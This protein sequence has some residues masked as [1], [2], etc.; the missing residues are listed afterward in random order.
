MEAWLVSNPEIEC[1]FAANDDMA[2]GAINAMEMA[3]RMDIKV[4]SVDANELGCIALK[5]GK[6]T[7][8]VAQDTFGYAHGR[9]GLCREAPPGRGS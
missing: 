4:F 1:I 9:C 5:E 6:L 3:D 2:L 7:A 8:T